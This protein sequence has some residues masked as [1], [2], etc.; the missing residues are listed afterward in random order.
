MNFG[1][2]YLVH[3]YIETGYKLGN[4]SQPPSA[5]VAKS[6]EFPYCVFFLTK[7]FLKW[8]LNFDNLEVV[9]KVRL[10]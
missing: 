4:V 6:P 7:V 8:C 3:K 10:T 5:R 9:T 1:E 2:T